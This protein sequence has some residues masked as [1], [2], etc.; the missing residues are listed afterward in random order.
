MGGISGDNTTPWQINIYFNGPLDPNTVNA[1][2]VQLVNLGSNPSQPLD[3]DIN[4]SGKLSYAT[5]IS[6]TGAT[7]YVLTI[8]LAA[9]GLTLTTDAYQ[10]TLFGSGSPVLASPQGIALDGENTVGDAPTGAQLR[11][12]VRQRV[13]R[14]Q[15]LQTPSSST[16]RRRRSSRVRSSSTPPAT[17]TSSATT[18]P[19]TPRPP[20]TA[21]SSS[22]TRN[23]CRLPGKSA[24]LDIG[25]ALPNGSGGLT[26]YLQRGVAARR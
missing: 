24:F 15:F 10:I 8:N 1:N 16:P 22:P 7:Q 9:S 5:T 18:S 11:T 21:R 6:A 13:S 14:R 12:P 26:T 4:L 17:Q 2:T 25:I 23:S 20:S 19:L 3:Q